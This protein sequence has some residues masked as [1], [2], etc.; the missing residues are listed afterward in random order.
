MNLKEL[1]ERFKNLMTQ[2]E[3][4][5]LKYEGKSATMTGQEQTE[6]TNLIDEADRV[7]GQIEAL[8]RQEGLAAFA[9]K[10]AN[11]LPTGDPAAPVNDKGE[12]VKADAPDP[13]AIGKK[14]FNKFL[15]KGFSGM[16][17]EDL[18]GIAGVTATKAYQ[19]D[20]PVSGGF[21]IAPQMFV[22]DLITLLKDEVFMRGLATCYQVNRAESLGIPS[23]DVDPSAPVWTAEISTGNEDTS[24]K[25]GKRDLKPHPLAKRVKL[26]NKLLRTAAM[27]PESIVRDRLGY[28]F[29]TTEESAFL[30]GSGADQP[31]GV[32][33]PSVQGIGTDRDF[34]GKTTGVLSADDFIGTLYN[35]KGQ[36]QNRA[37]WILHRS[38][39]MA[40]RLLKD[41]NGN[42]LWATGLGPGLGYA[43]GQPDTILGRPYKMSEYAPSNVSS[44]DY[45][46]I[47]GDFSRYVIA[48]ALDMQMQVLDQL[49]AETNQTGYIAR[50]ETDGMPVL[51]EAFSRLIIK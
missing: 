23:L 22:E 12:K 42:Y 8:E 10:S 19:A 40:V 37:T 29:S 3:A 17:E 33:T 35:L 6:W 39:V 41:A 1:Q 5:R 16:T 4:I 36:Y 13:K 46:A 15:V 48:T 31:L 47:C 11:P 44:G 28:K 9:A 38:I 45:V 34:Q 43:G 25:F 27:D 24:M 32:F 2:A 14:S 26:S 7:K 50:M 21:L 51:S 20:D 18:R 49:Y 30:N